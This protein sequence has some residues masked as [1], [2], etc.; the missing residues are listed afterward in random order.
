MTTQ[1]KIKQSI[2]ADIPRLAPIADKDGNVTSYW[3]L[4]FSSLSQALQ[5]N[6]KDE[7]IILPPLTQDEQDDIQALYT[8]YIGLPLPGTQPGQVQGLVLP[9]ISG[10]TIFDSTNR[11][12]KVFIITFDGSVPPNV[13]TASWKTYTVT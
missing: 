9:D 13:L 4:F 8:P 7:G 1:K 5:K 12:P 2:F 3:S 6:Y 10:Q 11:V